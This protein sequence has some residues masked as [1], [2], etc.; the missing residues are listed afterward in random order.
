[1]AFLLCHLKCEDY[2]KWR[3]VF[4]GNAPMRQSAGCKGAHIFQA[5]EDP[6]EV[7]LTLTFDD[8]AS[9][10]A[11]FTR[12]DVRDG[13]RASGVIGEVE[14]HLIEDAGRTPG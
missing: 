13:I 11:L 12:D 8:Q 2:A 1:M 3:Q 9:A 14:A 6:N 7:W 4:E 5:A 10:K